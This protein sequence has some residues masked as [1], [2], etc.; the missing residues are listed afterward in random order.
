ML[1]T[2]QTPNKG[3]L[4]HCSLEQDNKTCSRL[5]PG[6]RLYLIMIFL[7]FSD[8][9]VPTVTA[10]LKIQSPAGKHRWFIK[11]RLLHLLHYDSY[12]GLATVFL[13]N[14]FNLARRQDKRWLQLSQESKW[15]ASSADVFFSVCLLS[16]SVYL[17]NDWWKTS[18]SYPKMGE[19]VKVFMELALTVCPRLCAALYRPRTEANS[20]KERCLHN[21]KE[22][23]P[24]P[25]TWKKFSSVCF[26]FLSW[27]LSELVVKRVPSKRQMST[28]L[29]EHRSNK[30][31]KRSKG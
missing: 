9:F 10:R 12:V 26:I 6:C 30:D 5:E 21:G 2:L 18:S 27:L 1:H 3:C 4:R 31:L 20:S 25:K 13:L 14:Q 22:L 24:H 28:C 7:N 29:A 11:A 8:S 15:T 16:K 19:P 17:C 23:S